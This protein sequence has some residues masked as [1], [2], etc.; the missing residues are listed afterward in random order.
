[1][2]LYGYECTLR[3][4]SQPANLKVSIYRVSGNSSTKKKIKY[5][6]HFQTKFGNSFFYLKKKCS[7]FLFI[8]KKF[9]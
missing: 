5:L 6:R 2:I 9:K 7:K 1:M 4:I 3:E 8:S